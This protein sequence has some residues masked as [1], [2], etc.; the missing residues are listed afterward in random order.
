MEYYSKFLVQTAAG[1]RQEDFDA[2]DNLTMLEGQEVNQLIEKATEIASEELRENR[3][4]DRAERKY[5]ER[6]EKI[7]D[8]FPSEK[9]LEGTSYYIL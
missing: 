1:V 5:K 6:A 8:R 2:G 3:D 7:G 4:A 9:E